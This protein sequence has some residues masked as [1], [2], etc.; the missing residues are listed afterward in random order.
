[1]KSS[2]CNISNYIKANLIVSE[3]NYLGKK[4][5]DELIVSYVKR[6]DGSRVKVIHPSFKQGTECDFEIDFIDDYPEKELKLL[7]ENAGKRCG[8]GA[9]RPRFGRFE[10]TSFK[11]A[12]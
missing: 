2:R 8:I 7:I 1:M 3:F 4:K 5:P 11:K 9:R 12:K 6:K 10:V